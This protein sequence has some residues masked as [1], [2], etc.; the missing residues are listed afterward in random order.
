MIFAFKSMARA[1][2]ACLVLGA[3]S[4]HG[5]GP[6]SASG[7]PTG[8]EAPDSVMTPDSDAAARTGSDAPSGAPDGAGAGGTTAS[9][10]GATAGAPGKP[11]SQTALNGAA[12][13]AP[14]PVNLDGKTSVIVSA[15]LAQP[16]D[17]EFNP[18]V[19]DELWIVNFGDS[20]AVIVSNASSDGRSAQRRLDVEAESHFMPSPTALAFGA[21]E[22]TI[23]D[24]RGKMV[25][26]T[27]AT[28]PGVDRSYMGPTLW[29]SDLRI[30]AIAKEDREPPF[31]GADTGGEG[32]GSHI[33]MLHLTP[34]C[35]GIAW[36]GA[37]NVYWTYSSSSAMFVKYD[38]AKD[39]GIGN[40]DHSDGSVWRYAVS[41]LRPTM[42][43]P[44]HLE[45]DAERKV[46]YMAD[47]GNSRVV[48]FDPTTAG[49]SRPLRG[50]ENLDDL[51][52]ALDFEPGTLKDLVPSSYGLKL[53]VGLALH[54]DRLYVSDNETSTIHRFALDGAPLGKA[55]IADVKRGGLAGLTFGPDGKLYFVD[56]LANRVLRLENDF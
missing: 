4:Q 36:E 53:P 20:S 21:R 50:S 18:F 40:T 29:T 30:F 51:H 39:H 27:F 45:Y 37:G 15:D 8:P 25:E 11:S 26:G 5:S 54:A 7:E 16:S 12:G 55:V 48:M 22:T 43:A 13:G 38:F 32:P 28:C 47:T 23:V 6:Q 44:S 41:G 9:R 42:K 3:C 35:T 56:M 14:E 46:L 17:L 1:S 24:A 31:N 34:A 2:A 10:P 49:A 33:D 52:V 19:K